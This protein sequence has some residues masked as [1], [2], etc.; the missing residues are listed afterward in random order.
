MKAV[1]WTNYGPPEVLEVHDIP[2][3]KPGP[4]DVLIKVHASTVTAGDCEARRFQFPLLFRVP[5]RLYF[6]LFKPRIKTLGQELAGEVVET[7]DQ[8]KDFK[9]GDRVV[10]PTMMRFGAHAEYTCLPASY[11]IAHIPDALSYEEAATIPTGGMNGLHFINKAE[12]KTGDHVLINGAG[13]S[14]GTYAL[15]IAKARGAR[16]TCVD[17]GIKLDMLRT[18]GADDGIDY[19]KEDFT[20]NGRNYDV[21]IDIVGKADFDNSIAALNQ[22]GRLVLGNP[23]FTGMMRGIKVSKTTS[24]KVL[25]ELA[26]YKRPVLSNMA[27]QI[28]K[29]EIKV[30]IDRTFSL[31]EM[32]E[33]HHY[34]EKGLKMG[35]VIIV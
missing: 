16:V 28:A 26:G 9:P 6:G 10:A 18:L 4:K 13:G 23:T 32:I 21:I 19:T 2:R 20:Q 35:N 33:A 8:V 31:D 30:V 15:Q 34:I 11:P 12:V 7:G 5:M 1:I 27:E 25:F 24:K 14:I 29:G 22:G 17:S 3:P